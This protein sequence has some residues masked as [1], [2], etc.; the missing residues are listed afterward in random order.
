MNE[1]YLQDP[2]ACFR[3]YCAIK[4]H[5]STESYDFIKYN[6]RINIPRSAYTKRKDKMFFD[7]LAKK[8][9]ESD[10]TY[11]FVSQFIENSSLWVGNILFE[12]EDSE[13]KY[14]SW[15][16]RIAMIYDNYANDIYN[17]KLCHKPWSEILITQNE[18]DHP[19][20]FKLVQQRKINPETY[21][22]LNTLFNFIHIN[23]EKLQN[24]TIF[25]TSNLKYIK[26]K[27]FLPVS[28]KKIANM[29]PKQ[30]TT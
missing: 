16:N 24:D 12:K 1:D 10:N 22:I 7:Y 14:R 29:T 5:F 19:Y 25:C 3:T 27:V 11:F 15:V 18:I 17:L 13:K 26:Y 30:L 2:F 21:T 4:S 8:I 28:L 6:G 20:I 23:I 9:S